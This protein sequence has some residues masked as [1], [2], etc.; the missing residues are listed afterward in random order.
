MDRTATGGD[1]AGDAEIAA[2]LDEKHKKLALVKRKLREKLALISRQQQQLARA[3]QRA[4]QLAA[5]LA[6]IQCAAADTSESLDQIL[7][8]EDAED[9]SQQIAELQ[10]EIEQLKKRVLVAQKTESKLKDALTRLA[11]LEKRVLD[12]ARTRSLVAELRSENHR[13]SGQLA[14]SRALIKQLKTKLSER[15]PGTD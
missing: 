8:F 7:A 6:E 9:D 2:K 4:D 3:N 12:G 15:G 10:Q 5:Q 14:Q 11:E 13:I 1:V